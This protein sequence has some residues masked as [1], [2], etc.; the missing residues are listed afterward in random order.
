MGT[1]LIMK[2]CTVSQVKKGKRRLLKIPFPREVL[3]LG[4]ASLI[5]LKIR[6]LSMLSEPLLAKDRVLKTTSI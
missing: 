4:L 1:V 2:I 3:S 5:R 6:H